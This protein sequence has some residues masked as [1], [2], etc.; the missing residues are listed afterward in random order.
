MA[1]RQTTGFLDSLSR[2]ASIDC[3]IVNFSA[4]FCHHGPP[5][6]VT[7]PYR[8][9]RGCLPLLIDSTEI[10]AA[11]EVVSRSWWKFEGGVISG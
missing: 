2:L 5:P 4:M 11:D 8:R 3:T 6:A 9:C 1:L 7:I 10:K